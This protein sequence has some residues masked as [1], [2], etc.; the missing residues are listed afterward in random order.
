VADA[1]GQ[2]DEVLFRIEQFPGA[3]EDIR[4][5]F[6]QERSAVAASTALAATPNWFFCNRPMVR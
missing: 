4:E 6:T 1:I 2:D 5:T 3:E